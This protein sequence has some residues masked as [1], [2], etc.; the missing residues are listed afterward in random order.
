MKRLN[1]L[2][3]TCDDINE[4]VFDKRIGWTDYAASTRSSSSQIYVS[5]KYKKVIISPDK[6]ME[7]QLLT[8]FRLLAVRIWLK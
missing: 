3:N 5:I 8:V 7:H 6:R 2:L 4:N 1:I